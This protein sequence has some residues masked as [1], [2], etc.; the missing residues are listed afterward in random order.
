MLAA[1]VVIA[2]PPPTARYFICPFPPLSRRAVKPLAVATVTGSPRLAKSVPTITQSGTR[3]SPSVRHTFLTPPMLFSKSTRSR[4]KDHKSNTCCWASGG[5]AWNFSIT[6]FCSRFSRKFH[7][8][9]QCSRFYYTQV[10]YTTVLPLVGCITATRLPVSL[11][12]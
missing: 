8:A 11:P 12:T 4:Q 3:R 5:R 7:T 1:A 9:I 6:S 2:Q 10:L